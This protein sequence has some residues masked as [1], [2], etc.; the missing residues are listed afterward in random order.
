MTLRHR[1][2]CMLAD[3]ATFALVFV[4]L[5]LWACGFRPQ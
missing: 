5:A 1:L 3:V 4:P 2:G